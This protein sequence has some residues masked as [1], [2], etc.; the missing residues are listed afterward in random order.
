[1]LSF[2]VMFLVATDTFLIAPLLPA[3]TSRFGNSSTNAGWMVSSYAIGYCVTAVFAGPLS[4]HLDRK[5]VLVL[6]MVAFSL[7]TF[8]C[9]LA[10][11]FPSM[12]ALR[13]MTGMAAAVGTPQVWAAIPQLVPKEQIISMMAAPTAGLTIAQLAGVPVGSFLSARSTSDPFFVVGVAAMLA[14][15]AVVIWFPAVPAR[16]VATRPV[17]QYAS[18]WRTQYA[19]GRFAAYLV[20]QTGN[21]AMLSFAATWFARDF[22]LSQTGIGVS[23][24]VLGLGNTVGAVLGPRLVATLTQGR[25]LLIAMTCYLPVYALLP[26]SHSIQIAVVILTV[27]FFLG[28][29]IFPVFQALLQSLTETARGTVSSL[30]NVLMYA[31]STIAGILGGPLLAW[32]PGFWG[33]S[34]LAFTTA[35]VSLILWATSGSIQLRSASDEQRSANSE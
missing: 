21:F 35:A 3:L 20:F 16:N 8:A 19:R 27:A 12:L 18:L 15:L 5:R 24:I 6:G 30:T 4:D 10:W 14:T 31:G 33:I 34:L 32:F 7:S 13:F 11:S 23:M 28:G 17:D 25:A 9:G 29:T 26:L 2:L 22:G 1:M